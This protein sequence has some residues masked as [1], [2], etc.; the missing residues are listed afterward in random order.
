MANFNDKDGHWITTK[1]GKHLFIKDEDAIDKQEREIGEQKELTKKLDD[2]HNKQETSKFTGDGEVRKDGSMTINYLHINNAKTPNYGST[3]GQNIEPSGEYMTFIG[4]NDF[5]VQAP[6][7]TYGTI[8]FKKPL[9]LE[10]K[11]TSDKGWKKDLS[12]MF[13]GK[14]GKALSNAVK[15]AGY[16]AIVTWE[17]FKGKKSWSEIVNLAGEKG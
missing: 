11:S 8:T 16:D 5:R 1:T 2:E 17:N 12:E 14:T 15:K 3:F 4:E 10:H 9:I 13:G 7:F 6:N